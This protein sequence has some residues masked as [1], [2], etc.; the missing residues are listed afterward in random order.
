ME[1][2]YIPSDLL[3]LVGKY[4]EYNKTNDEIFFLLYDIF[5]EGAENDY[6]HSIR[7]RDKFNNIM[8]KYGLKTLLKIP[9]LPRQKPEDPNELFTYTLVYKEQ[10]IITVDLLKELIEYLFNSKELPIFREYLLAD[11]IEFNSFLKEKK[12]NIR[13]FIEGSES[14]PVFKVVS[15]Y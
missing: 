10:D 9:N 12:S 5:V 11:S 7:F 8:K 13:I 14:K 4:Q 6:N 3:N 2:R 1:G 15:I